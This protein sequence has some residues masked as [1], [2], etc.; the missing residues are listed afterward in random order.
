M[1]SSDCNF[2]S[3]IDVP[4]NSHTSLYSLNDLSFLVARREKARKIVARIL[5]ERYLVYR[6]TV[7]CA[8]YILLTYDSLKSHVDGIVLC[9]AK[10]LFS[11]KRVATN[12]KSTIRILFVC[13]WPLLFHS[14]TNTAFYHFLCAYPVV[15]NLLVCLIMCYNILSHVADYCCIRSLNRYGAFY[16]PVVE[17]C[18]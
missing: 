4:E 13:T 18:C 11:F 10:K 14:T 12:H 1:A 16:T 17:N 7:E 3:S 6:V 8:Y 15:L 2:N 9:V 5:T